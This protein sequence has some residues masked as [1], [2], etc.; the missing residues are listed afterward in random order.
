M[1]RLPC[2]CGEARERCPKIVVVE[3]GC[4]VDLAREE[5]LSQGTPRH[6]PDAE[7]FARRGGLPLQG[8]LSRVNIRSERPSQ[9]LIGI[10]STNGPRTCFREAEM[11]DLALLNEILHRACDI[12][13]GNLRIDPMLIEQVER[14][15][16]RF[17]IASAAALM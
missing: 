9:A 5:A 6:E 2:L 12:F 13:D 7:L 11:P 10:R 3:L 8:L 15:L 14:V 1:I 17:S 16:R 4:G